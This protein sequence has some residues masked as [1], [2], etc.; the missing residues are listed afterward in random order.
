MSKK[1][2]FFDSS[3]QGT[4]EFALV[5]PLLLLL[6][7]GIIDLSRLFYH[8]SVINET[9]R[10]SLRMA[11]VGNDIISITEKAEKLITPLTGEVTSNIVEDVDDEGNPCTTITLTP[12]SGTDVIMHIT[13]VYSS[14]LQ[15]GD[16]LRISAIY[17]MKY[18]TPLNKILG[19]NYEIRSRYYTRVEK[20]PSD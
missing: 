7:F 13:P 5:L 16:T 1:L 10:E 3:G 20:P 12:A 6:I 8:H 4:V 18:I 14:V 11:S 2:F 19:S 9:A 17:S 15:S